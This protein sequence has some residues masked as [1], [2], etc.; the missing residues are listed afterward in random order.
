[1]HQKVSNAV[2]VELLPPKN[3]VI[4]RRRRWSSTVYIS[5]R[6]LPLP[7]NEQGLVHVDGVCALPGL[8]THP[9]WPLSP[10][11]THRALRQRRGRAGLP[12]GQRRSRGARV[13][14]QQQFVL[15][16]RWRG[17][18][19]SSLIHQP[20]AAS[21]PLGPACHVYTLDIAMLNSAVC[22]QCDLITGTLVWELLLQSLYNTRMHLPE[23]QLPWISSKSV[24]NTANYI[25]LENK[26]LCC[27]LKF[28]EIQL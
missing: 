10:V 6:P 21:V 20:A 15:G 25:A 8:L 18:E 26:Y 2:E 16:Q 11:T 5:I 1:M 4:F 23:H 9:W 3:P 7:L 14:C 27:L 17:G 13:S 22:A 12:G 19:V 28:G 24:G